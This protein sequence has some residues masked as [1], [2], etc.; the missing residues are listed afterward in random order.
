MSKISLQERNKNRKKLIEKYF[1]K[2]ME[3]KKKSKDPNLT[4]EER[5]S[6]RLLLG[7]LPL[8][9]SPVRYRFRC[10]ITGRGRGNLRDFAMSRTEFRRKASRGEL[11][12]ITKSSW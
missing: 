12:G 11:P 4:D 7:Q 6:C 1:K 9:S 10:S 8:N 2:R 5:F 3:L